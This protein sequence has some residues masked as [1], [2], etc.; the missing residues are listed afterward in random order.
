MVRWVVFA[1]VSVPFLSGCIS[2]CSDATGAVHGGDMLLADAAPDPC[3][4]DDAGDT[5][6]Y[7][8]ACYFG[9]GGKATCGGLSECHSSSTDPGVVLQPYYPP[10]HCAS[11]DDCY[12]GFVLFNTEP[13]GPP[14]DAGDEG[15]ADAGDA[16]D[17]GVSADAGMTADA[18]DGGDAGGASDGAADAFDPTVGANNTIFWLRKQ[19]GGGGEMPCSGAPL[20]NFGR[21]LE[22]NCDMATGYSFSDTDMARIQQWIKDGARDN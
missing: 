13:G 8:Y 21:G 7:L 17:G 4:A 15:G 3:V 20:A 22:P 18:G 2:G 11:K 6:S 10:F 1:V 12:Q 9:P 16:G 5:W 19:G 14:G